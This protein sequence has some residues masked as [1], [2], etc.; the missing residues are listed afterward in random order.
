MDHKK[1]DCHAAVLFLSVSFDGR[2][3]DT[4]V[5][6]GKRN[7]LS[8]TTKVPFLRCDYARIMDINSPHPPERSCISMI[9]YK[10]LSLADIF[11]DCQNKFDNDKY[12]FLDLLAQTIVLDEFVPVSFIS[13]FHALT[14]KPRTHLLF[15]MLRV[16]LLQRIFPFHPILF[17]SS[18]SSSPSVS[19]R[20]LFLQV[21]QPLI[22]QEVETFYL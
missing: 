16:L 5:S 3:P 7:N 17:Y 4:P 8:V 10:H 20:I 2:I 14:G 1:E 12:A 6:L 13:H 22:K 21:S 11:I 19:F 18:F 15:P 9:P